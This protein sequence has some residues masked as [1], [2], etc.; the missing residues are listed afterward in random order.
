MAGP[1]D[2]EKYSISKDMMG[3]CRLT[4]KEGTKEDGG[5]WSCRLF[6]QKDKTST[7]VA[8]VGK[9]RLSQLKIKN[10]YAATCDR[11]IRYQIRKIMAMFV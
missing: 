7:K 3:N 11:R 9:A 4:I 8:L 6:K 2:D 10:F 1:Q 5:E